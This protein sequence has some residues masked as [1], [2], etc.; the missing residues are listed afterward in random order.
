MIPVEVSTTG[1]IEEFGWKHPQ[2]DSLKNRAEVEPT[3]AAG[4]GAAY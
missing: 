3:E 4:G 2:P 1:F